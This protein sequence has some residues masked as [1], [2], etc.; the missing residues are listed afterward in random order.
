MLSTNHRNLIAVVALALA[1]M[2]GC[3]RGCRIPFPTPANNGE[4]IDLG[5]D[6]DLNAVVE[7]DDA[8]HDF[9]AV[10]DDGT[11]V[12]WGESVEVFDV[13]DTNLRAALIGN[14]S[15][16]V[17]GDE[18]TLIVSSN[19]GESWESIDL[20]TNADF[21]AIA[22]FAGRPIIVGDEVIVV[23]NADG[24]WSELAAPAGG[25]GL[26]RGVTEGYAVGL[27][28]VIW[29]ASE[30]H[31]EWVAEASG[32]TADLF[33]VHGTAAVGASGTL[34]V[35]NQNGWTRIDTGVSTDFL[36]FEPSPF[37][38]P[39]WEVSGYI[40][41]AD[42]NIYQVG[43]NLPNFASMNTGSMGKFAGARSLAINIY[44]CASV[45]EAGSATTPPTPPGCF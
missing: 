24:T 31:G 2:T 10:G 41:G 44:G 20:Q 30:P 33:S 35:R 9:L 15:W 42:G 29:Q 26:L 6:V 11:V 39:H 37:W 14:L 45:G 21:Y 5:I 22:S 27:G 12:T 3:D 23:R 13:G 43:P 38:D 32:V 7:L 17:V 18:G 19:L 34:L 36:D 28:G 16:W 4:P 40:L 1:V 25:W 8:H